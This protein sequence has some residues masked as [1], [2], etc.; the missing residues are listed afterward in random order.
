MT[1]CQAAE[2]SSCASIIIEMR[3]LECSVEAAYRI[4]DDIESF[5]DLMRDELQPAGD[6]LGYDLPDE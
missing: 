4:I 6:C 5:E 2:F 3:D 1:F